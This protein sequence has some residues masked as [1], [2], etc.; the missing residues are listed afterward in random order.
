MLNAPKYAALVVG[1]CLGFLLLAEGSAAARSTST[2]TWG[3][4]PKTYQQYIKLCKNRPDVAA[5]R[6][7]SFYFGKLAKKGKLT[8]ARRF[9]AN[10]RLHLALRKAARQRLRLM[11]RTRDNDRNYFRQMWRRARY[12]LLALKTQVFG[13]PRAAAS[14][15]AGSPFYNTGNFGHYVQRSKKNIRTSWVFKRGRLGKKKT[16][17]DMFKAQKEAAKRR[18]KARKKNR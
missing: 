2:K 15:K 10:V 4:R 11:E 6:S 14:V 5:C 8:G 9:Y 3:E 17:G 7:A 13:R 18:E 12:K 1:A 16:K